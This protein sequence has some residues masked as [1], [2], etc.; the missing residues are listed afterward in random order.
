MKV[1][2]LNEVVQTSHTGFQ[3]FKAWSPFIILSVMVTIWTTKWF[4]AF[5]AKGQIFADTI[6]KFEFTEIHNMIFKMPPIAS[7]PKSFDVVYT[8]NPLSATGTAIFITAII[9]LFI[10]RLNLTTATKTMGETL[11]RNLQNVKC[12]PFG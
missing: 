9:T 4:K 10:F 8:F 1:V 11:F 12:E 5:F 3:I 6:F 7:A 2:E